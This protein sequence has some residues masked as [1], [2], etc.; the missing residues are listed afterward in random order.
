MLRKILSVCLLAFIFSAVSGVNVFARS[1]NGDE[2]TLV[3]KKETQA[4]KE[5]L[6]SVFSAKNDSSNQ[7]GKEKNTLAEYERNKAQGRKFSTTTKIL[8]G[9][10]IAA[11]VIGVVVFAASRDK[12]RTF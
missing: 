11:A 3:V 5:D 12:I 9:V 4:G 1:I 8:I 2:K 6:K 7:I 10:G